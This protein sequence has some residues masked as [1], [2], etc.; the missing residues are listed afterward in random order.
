MEPVSLEAVARAESPPLEGESI[1][2][3]AAR[4]TNTAGCCLVV[5][6]CIW[7]AAFT[8]SLV[9]EE[10]REH[11]KAGGPVFVLFISVLMLIAA[12]MIYRA[13][14]AARLGVRVAASG[15]TIHNMNGDL[16]VGWSD[17]VRFEAVV[18]GAFQ[19][20]SA[21]GLVRL[22]DGSGQLIQGTAIHLGIWQH[23][24]DKVD[25]CVLRLNG[26]LSGATGSMTGSAAP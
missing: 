20:R 9:A 23:K 6:G 19:F 17:I 14:R 12:V 24:S 1:Y 8:S 2:L 11:L 7:F 10:H 16:Q 15:I 13:L 3:L 21:V 26:L 18:V 22:K 25:Q 4:L 5:F